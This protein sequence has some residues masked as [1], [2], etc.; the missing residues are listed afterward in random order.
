MIF[1]KFEKSII[2]NYHRASQ[3]PPMLLRTLTLLTFLTVIIP[4]DKL[5]IPV[6]LIIIMSV[7]GIAALQD[8]II[9][10]SLLI[11]ITFA[12]VSIAKGIKPQIDHKLNLLIILIFWA[13]LL[14]FTKQFIQYYDTISLSTLI[15]FLLF[16]TINLVNTI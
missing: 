1:V 2:L 9:G 12:I 15:I 13:Y 7:L 11:T 5:A 8:L 10:L 6:G 16:S 4:G 3:T 14:Q